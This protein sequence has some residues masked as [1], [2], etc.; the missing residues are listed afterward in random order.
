[1]IR[2]AVDPG[3]NLEIYKKNLSS[4]VPCIP[5]IGVLLCTIFFLF[6]FQLLIFLADFFAL[7]NSVPS[8]DGRD[9][10]INLTQTKKQLKILEEAFQV[11]QSNDHTNHT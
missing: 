7:Q 4:S 5:A 9:D 3:N 11:Q 6:L 10:L 2:L 1:M 8:T